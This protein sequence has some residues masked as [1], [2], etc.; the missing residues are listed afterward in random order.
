MRLPLHQQ[1]TKRDAMR[2]GVYIFVKEVSFGF[3][4]GTQ[5]GLLTSEELKVGPKSKPKPTNFE[6]FTPQAQ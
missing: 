4:K 5:N 1:E 2:W 3:N 6:K